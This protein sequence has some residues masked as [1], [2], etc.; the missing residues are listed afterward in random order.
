[1]VGSQCRPCQAVLLDQSLLWLLWLLFHHRLLQ[2]D[3]W[4]QSAL[5]MGQ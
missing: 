3:L 1:M 5:Q 4:G 2:P